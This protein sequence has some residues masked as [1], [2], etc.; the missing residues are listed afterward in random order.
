MHA[1][2]SVEQKERDLYTLGASSRDCAPPAEQPATTEAATPKAGATTVAA[3]GAEPGAVYAE[4]P[5]PG[6]FADCDPDGG[7]LGDTSDVRVLNTSLFFEASLRDFADRTHA[8]RA[9]HGQAP[10]QAEPADTEVLEV[11]RAFAEGRINHLNHGLCPGIIAGRGSRDRECRVCQALDG[12]APAA[13]AWPV[14]VLKFER[15]TPGRENEMPRVVSCNWMP[16]G[17]Y[18]V[19]LAAAPTTQPAPQQEAQEPVVHPRR[20]VVVKWRNSGIEAC[21]GIADA[22]GCESAA[23]DMRAMLTREGA[24]PKPSPA[25]QEGKD[26]G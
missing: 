25:A 21:A 5:E 1:N 18:E 16:D 4:L 23:I 15:G 7:F 8:L 20:P 2:T 6:L 14:A 11:L 19:Y 13:V 17:E 9:S 24:A 10:A 22:Y 26:H 12:A 3:L